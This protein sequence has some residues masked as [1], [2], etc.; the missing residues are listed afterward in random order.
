MEKAGEVGP[1]GGAIGFA[2][3]ASFTAVHYLW[4]A[5][6]ERLNLALLENASL[7][8]LIN[9]AVDWKKLDEADERIFATVAR[10]APKFETR[11][12]E[13]IAKL[14][15]TVTVGRMTPEELERVERV[16][17]RGSGRVPE[18]LPLEKLSQDLK[19]KCLVASMAIPFGLFRNVQVG[20]N[21]YV[22]GGVVDNIPILPPGGGPM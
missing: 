12:A 6:Y 7:N 8:H 21:L 16:M 10:F 22:D 18:Y 11:I 3:A 20:R 1:V 17:A 9:E 14:R 4:P 15:E 19:R 5:I 13:Q 2:L